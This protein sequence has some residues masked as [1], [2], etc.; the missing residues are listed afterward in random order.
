MQVYARDMRDYH[1]RQ[2]VEAQPYPNRITRSLVEEF[3][4]KPFSYEEILPVFEN[5]V[6][7]P[8][9]ADVPPVVRALADLSLLLFNTNEFLYVY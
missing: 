6:A 3:S 8:K 1:R 5:Y 9:P 7:D 2:K 4:G